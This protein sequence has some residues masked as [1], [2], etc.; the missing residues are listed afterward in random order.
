MVENCLL[1][2]GVG[3]R[4]LEHL[5]FRSLKLLELLRGVLIQSYSLYCFWLMQDTLVLHYRELK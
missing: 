5:M 4:G 2:S 3:D 1:W